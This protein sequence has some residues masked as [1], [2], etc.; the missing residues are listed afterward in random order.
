MTRSLEDY[1][2]AV[3]GAS[4][5]IG[6]GMARRLIDGGAQVFAAGGG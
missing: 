5:G 2:T 6:R 3:V 4:S 1:T